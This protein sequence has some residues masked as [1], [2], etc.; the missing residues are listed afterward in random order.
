MNKRRFF[1]GLD[2]G[3]RVDYSAVAV[4][5]RVAQGVEQFDHLR[6]MAKKIPEPDLLVVRYLERMRLG[7]PYTAVVSRVGKMM[8]SPVMA[9]RRELVVDATGVGMPVV[10]MLRS[11]RLGCAL[12]PVVLTGGVGEHSDGAVFHVPKVDVLAAL[13]AALEQERLR[14]ARSL[15]EAGTLVK[16]LLDVRMTP[17]RRGRKRL[18]ADGYGQH[19]DLVMAVGL[20]CWAAERNYGAGERD[21][22]RIV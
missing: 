10:E 22:G 8:T 18:G 12:T 11:A 17:T 14:I 21:T 2:L 13:Q 3:Q 1:V 19:D 5:E 7:T 20:A 6:W 4:V 16:E 9:G 15:K